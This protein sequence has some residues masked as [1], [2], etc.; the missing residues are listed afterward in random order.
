MPS[1]W[2][3]ER[4]TEHYYNKAKAEGY[5]S[6]ASYK[7]KQLNEEFKFFEGAKWV[8]DLGAAPGGWLQVAGESI[9]GGLVLGVDLKEIDDLYME[10]VETIVGDVRDPAV[11]GAILGRFHGEK[12]DVVMSDMAQNV[13]GVWEVDDLRQIHLARIALSI[14]DKLLR[15]DGWMIVKVF[16]GKE[17]EAFINEM[18]AMF[19]KVIIVKPLASRKGSAEV[20]VV[21]KNL[22]R[23]R[24]L[25]EDFNP[26][27]K[28]QPIAEGEQQ[29][30]EPLPGE[31]LPDYGE[32]EEYG[33]K[34]P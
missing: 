9:D 2:L 6:R 11:Q 31:N 13:M 29:E 16:Q 27:G 19:E 25:P 23:D 1:R 30:E 32:P 14:A 17:H 12:A 21:A 8:L 20:Y 7:L 24:V 33:K 34:K 3:H 10:N 26:E 5:R 22:R 28:P 4:K 15:E 18:R